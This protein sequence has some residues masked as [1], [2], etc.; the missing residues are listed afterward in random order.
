MSREVYQTGDGKN[1]LLAKILRE[2]SGG[3]FSKL[4]AP[5]GAPGPDGAAGPDGADGTNGANGAPGANGTN[6]TNGL[7][8]AAGTNGTNGTNGAPGANGTN[9]AAGA[10]GA[11]G[12]TVPGLITDVASMLPLPVVWLRASS[13][14]L[15]D[16]DP[17]ASWTN[18][19]SLGG[20]WVQATAANQPVYVAN[21]LGTAS[22][23]RFRNAGGN[24]KYLDG[25]NP[26]IL[27]N[28]T[29][30][31][32]PIYWTAL[33]VVRCAA[34]SVVLG[35]TGAT[36]FYMTL[37]FLNA[38]TYDNYCF[39]G[40]INNNARAPGGAFEGRKNVW[41]ACILSQTAEETSAGSLVQFEGP[42]LNRGYVGNVGKVETFQRIGYTGAGGPSTTD[43]DLAEL[44]VW[45][46]DFSA[47]AYRQIF[48]QYLRPRYSALP[49]GNG[50]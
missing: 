29:A 30:G 42:G 50:G 7:P 16:T 17:V 5:D 20:D 46:T 41:A 33:A 37:K 19:G 26:I 22:A 10:N 3:S 2:I 4:G 9:G 48:Y 40:K 25:P 15:A 11:A 12:L 23:V 35:E 1:A 18:E 6:G 44:I 47:E 28:G 14:V 45:T 36:N 24:Q 13:L 27:R 38:G 34:V 31:T 21:A 49:G 8:G 39:D 43:M 32:T